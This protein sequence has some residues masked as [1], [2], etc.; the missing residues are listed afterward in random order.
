MH[1]IHVFIGVLFR[2]LLL[3][4]RNHDEILVVNLM[5]RHQLASLMI[6]RKKAQLDYVD[7]VLFVQIKQVWEKWKN[8]LVVVKPE[9]VIRWE[10]ARF[11]KY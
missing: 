6:Q 5:L 1:F 2:G 10:R 4:F 7:R 8:A 3:L 9:T 11:Q